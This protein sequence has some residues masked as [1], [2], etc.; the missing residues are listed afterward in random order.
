VFYH[1][2]EVYYSNV[3]LDF[4]QSSQDNVGIIPKSRLWHHPSIS[5][6]VN[7]S[8]LSF[9]STLTDTNKIIK[10][11]IFVTSYIKTKQQAFMPHVVVCGNM[12]GV[13]S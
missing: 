7:H 6:P 5:V 1:G 12:M 9:R 10:S 2:L 4:L 8:C 11:L 13:R 3:F